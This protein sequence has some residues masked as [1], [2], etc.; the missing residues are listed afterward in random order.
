L[1]YFKNVVLLKAALALTLN[2][3]LILNL[4]LTLTI[5]LLTL[6]NKSC[7]FGKNILQAKHKVQ[8]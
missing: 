8:I 5:D 7:Y 6:K 3:A 1:V 4:A 2:P